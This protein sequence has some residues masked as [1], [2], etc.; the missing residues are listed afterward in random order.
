MRTINYFSTIVL[1][2]AALVVSC[3]ED[4][5]QQPAAVTGVELNSS[6]LS[7]L[8]GTDT[9]LVATVLPLDAADTGVTWTS[10][11]STIAVVENGK[12]TAIEA[13]GPVNITVT[14]NDGGFT[15]TCAV[16]VVYPPETALLP[17]NVTVS[18]VCGGPT[19]TANGTLAEA[20]F[21]VANGLAVTPTGIIYVGD[22]LN[23][24]VQKVDVAANSVTT[25]AGPPPALMVF[26]APSGYVNATG[27]DARFTNPAALTLDKAGNVYV[28]DFGNCAIRKITPEGVVTTHAGNYPKLVGFSDGR[29]SVALFRNPQGITVDANGTIYVADDGNNRVRKISEGMVSTLAGDG[30]EE[31]LDGPGATARFIGP[32]NVATDS[33]GNVFVLD[34]HRLRKINPAGVVSTL[35]GGELPGA[36]DGIGDAASFNSPSDLVVDPN[37]YIYVTDL[38]NQCIRRVTPSGKVTTIAG[39]AGLAGSENGS[40]LQATFINPIAIAMDGSGNLYVLELDG[41]TT[42]T[43]RKITINN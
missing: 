2:L 17:E 4:D 30:T 22:N 1:A 9:T 32:R 21:F 41:I 24:R 11:D 37:G 8:I 25:L 23:F 39:T 42:S 13:G 14:T 19:G 35:A 34:Q 33:K 18:T 3:G 7:L 6:S 10:S 27:S 38:V 26:M 28:A 40:G 16:T 5:K 31:H 20:Q 29:D 15:A 43:V 36:D 12:V